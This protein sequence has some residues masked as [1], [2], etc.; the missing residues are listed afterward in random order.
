MSEQEDTKFC[1]GCGFKFKTSEMKE[2]KER[3]SF[4]PARPRLNDIVIV[5]H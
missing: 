3:V 5:V 4:F 2:R 1:S